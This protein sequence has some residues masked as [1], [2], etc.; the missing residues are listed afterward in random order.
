MDT[1]KIAKEA[2]T[3]ELKSPNK[4][5]FFLIHGY[6]GSP[7]DFNGLGN[8]L[9]KR[10]NANV[11]I[12]RL[13]GHGTKISDLDKLNYDDFLDDAEKELRKEIA[14]GMNI[15]IGGL[16]SGSLMAFDLA[17]RYPVKGILSA[18]AA[19]KFKFPLNIIRFIAPIIPIKYIKKPITNFEKRSR[20]G[21][22]NY[23][24]VHL[25]GFKAISQGKRRLR[26][27]MKDVVVPCVFVHSKGE[28]IIDYKS[29]KLIKGKISSKKTKNIVFSPK[30][31]REH[32]LF[33]SPYHKKIYRIL[34]DFVEENNLLGSTLAI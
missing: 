2:K 9:H 25:R 20:A 15:V 33:Y 24:Y 5:L 29:D 23:L 10:F 1:N 32:N 11:K 8:Y 27:L 7:T 21:S 18:S 22:F 28:N 3:I 17:A 13:I 30:R 6:S 14:K 4:N 19:Y 34:G 16:S 12:M 26:N 31:E